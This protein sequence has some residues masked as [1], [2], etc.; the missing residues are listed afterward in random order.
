MSFW[1]VT[2]L[3]SMLRTVIMVFFSLSFDAYNFVLFE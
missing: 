2:L 3:S 1:N